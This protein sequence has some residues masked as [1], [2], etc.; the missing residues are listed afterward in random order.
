MMAGESNHKG[1]FFVFE[2]VNGCGKSTQV[3]RARNWLRAN[4]NDFIVVW[5]KE[6]TDGSVG[7]HIYRALKN[8][9][10]LKLL[11]PTALQSWFA[12]DSLEHLKGSVIPFLSTTEAVVFLCDRYRYSLVHSAH[13]VSDIQR[14]IDLNVAILGDNLI[15]PDLVFIFDVSPKVAIERLKNSGKNLDAQETFE[16]IS[17]TR[18]NY[19]KIAELCPRNVH[20]IDSNKNEKEVFGEVS[21]I[22]KIEIERASLKIKR[23]QENAQIIKTL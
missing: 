3:L 19:L 6:P 11:G 5:A 9:Q 14:L 8:P 17:R 16:E 21:R 10:F 22:I 15:T 20:I 18:E 12:L 13:S 23:K 7:R 1:L 4:Y 2:G